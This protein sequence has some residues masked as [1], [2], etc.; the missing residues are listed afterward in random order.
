[1]ADSRPPRRILI[2]RPSA[3]GDV[4]RT[5][6]VLASLRRAYPQARIDWVVR[7]TFAPAIAAH[8]ALNEAILFPRARFARWWRSP[9][10]LGEMLGWFWDLRR[11]R[12]ELVLD[13]QGLGR[14]GLIS[15]LAAARRRVGYRQ[16]R[17]LAWLGYNVRHP[18]HPEIHTVDQMLSLL[19]E[20]GIE[21]VHDMRLHLAPADHDWWTHERRRLGLDGLRY[22]VFA[23]TARWPS[24]RWPIQRWRQLVRPLLDRGLQRLVVVGGPDETAQVEGL[25]DPAGEAASSVVDLVGQTTIGQTMAAIADADLVIANDSAPL[26][27]AV[28]F[29]R[30]CVALF[31][32]TDPALVGPYRRPEAVVRKYRPRPGETINYRDG[33][34]GDGLMRLIS[35]DD[36]LERVDAVLAGAATPP[37]LEETAR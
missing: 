7:D 8:P 4:C 12:Y 33:K 17:E 24:K 9:A 30:P 26:H 13:C 35:V 29:D 11:R 6:P 3:L 32:P 18:A 14:S 31:G 10:A 21:P 27:V 28:G 36:V 5:V 25:V 16:A 19:R 1:M 37:A 34:L 20:E 22:A 2:V 23:P 15:F